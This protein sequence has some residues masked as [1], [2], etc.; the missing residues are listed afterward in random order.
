MERAKQKKSFYLTRLRNASLPELVH[1]GRQALLTHRLK[2]ASR[3]T[4]A[5]IDV[6]NSPD[7]SVLRVPTL[8]CKAT[9]EMVM[10]VLNGRVQSLGA[11][12]IDLAVW[13]NR[14]RE[15]F[16]SDV[17]LQAADMTD[18]RAIWEPARLQHLTILLAFMTDNPSFDMANKAESF[19]DDAV[20][21]WIETNPF[22]FGPH[23]LS[24]MECGLRIPVFFFCLKL[25]Y[26]E[27]PPKSHCILEAIYQHAWWIS[28]RLSLYSSLGNHTIAESVGLIFAGAIYRKTREGEYW[29][30][31]GLRLLKK[32]L[33]HQIL[34]DGGPAEQSLNYHRF[35]LDLYWLCFDFLN[36]NNLVD[37]TDLK[38]RLIRGEDFLSAFQDESGHF[39]SIGDSDDGYAVAPGIAPARW[40]NGHKKAGITL[41]KDSGYTV[42]RNK[43]G[44]VLTF[45]HGPLGMP[46]F[47]NHGHA[48]ALA[49]TLSKDMKRILVD[50][51]TYR[52]NGVP[53]WRSYF[54]GTMAHN[55]VTIDR[56]DQAVQ[57]T[58][59]IWSK[60][61]NTRFQ[62]SS[63]HVDGFLVSAIHDGYTRLK[64][65][66]WHK[67]SV[68]F[69]QETNFLIRDSFF[70]DGTHDFQLNYHLHP[71]VTLTKVKDW[72][73]I[74]NQ[75]AKVF[76]RFVDE[77]DFLLVNGQEHP[78]L[79]W[80]APSYGIKKKTHVLT[81]IKRGS[82][83]ETVFVTAICTDSPLDFDILTERLSQVEQQTKNFEYLG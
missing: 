69:F 17:K 50:P 44:L 7:V 46:P 53:E 70:G 18:I 55:T 42:I 71:E 41:Y 65:P 15:T 30:D 20:Q 22:L 61:Y 68:F 34:E 16:F 8:V 45:D 23:Y 37:C 75:G 52:Y 66:V 51:G 82:P 67:R 32:E 60:P 31:R 77:H 1:R 2:W 36:K 29:L 33:K 40:R 9:P 54:K 81:R 21:R 10:E 64:E 27:N 63:E 25:L 72:W 73:L 47:F 26:P 59:F 48:D 5:F 11:D 39:P 78:P 76:V 24:A 56:L 12:P 13:E 19:C 3:R 4:K 79:G 35:V 83:R 62:D 49:I 28:K 57:E 74:D 38:G 80:Y 43:N 14:H 58:G 6:P